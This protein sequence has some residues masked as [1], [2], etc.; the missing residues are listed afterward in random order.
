[1]CVSLFSGGVFA[2]RREGWKCDTTAVAAA[3]VDD[4]EEEEEGKYEEDEEE[5]EEAERHVQSPRHP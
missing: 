5:E 2:G 3:A 1:M 4:E